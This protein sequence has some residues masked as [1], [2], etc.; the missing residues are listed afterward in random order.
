MVTRI[1]DHCLFMVGAHVAHDCQIGDHV[2]MANNATL[3]GP[4]RRSRIMPILGGLSRGAPVRAHRPARDD[5]R[6]VRGRARR[7]P[8]WPGDGRPR[9][10]HRAQHHRH[11][12][13][14]L[15]P[16]GH[17]GAAQRLSVAVPADRARSSDRVDETAERFAAIGPV[18]DIIALHPRRIRAARS[19]SR[20][21]RMADRLA[22]RQPPRHH[23]RRRRAAAAARSKPAAPPGARCSFW[24]SKARPSRR[25]SRA[26][27]MPGAGSAPPAR[28]LELL[29]ENGVERAGAGRRRAAA[30]AGRA[31]AGLAGGQVLRPGRL[32]RA[33]R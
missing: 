16:R 18:D 10:A 6:H 31:A 20:K 7:H 24:R 29:R 21:E 33:G 11:A 14:R 9:A 8:L 12:A 32:S 13:P 15:Q 17:P 27:R 3:G 2:I 26:C 23:R 25:R 4:C 22:G 1:G 5:R 28:G 19:A 30:V